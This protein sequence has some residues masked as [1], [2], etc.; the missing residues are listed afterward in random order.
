MSEEKYDFNSAQDLPHNIKPKLSSITF[1]DLMSFKEELLKELREYKSKTTKNINYEFEKYTQLIEKT[2]NKMDF[3]EKEKSTFLLKSEFTQEKNNILLEISVQQ[4]EIKKQI[5][6]NEVQIKNNSKEIQ[7]SIYRYDKAIIENLNVPG[8]VGSACRF[9]NLKEYILSN[10]DEIS[11]AVIANKKTSIEFKSFKKKMEISINQINEQ[12][13][14]LEY[15]ISNLVKSKFNELKEKFDSLYEA[16]NGK[17]TDES[18]KLNT[19]IDEKNIAIENI[20]A[21]VSEN[22][23]KLLENDALLKEELIKEIEIIKKSF[24]KIKKNIVNLTNLLMGKNNGLNKQMVINNFNNMMKGLYKEFNIDEMN[25]NFDNNNN[26]EIINNDSKYL[27]SKNMINKS[28]EKKRKSF[29]NNIKNNISFASQKKVGIGIIKTSINSSI[30]DYIAGKI[31]ADDA[32]FNAENIKSKYRHSKKTNNKDI[33]GNSKGIKN[34]DNI[35]NSN[36]KLSSRLSVNLNT[37]SNLFKEIKDI[38]SSFSENAKNFDNQN[39]KKRSSMILEKKTKSLNKII[40]NSFEHNSKDKIK[41]NDIINEE[42]SNKYTSSEESKLKIKGKKEIKNKRYTKDNIDINNKSLKLSLNEK[43]SKNHNSDSLTSQISSSSQKTDNSLDSSKL[44]YNAIKT[45][46]ENEKQNLN[47]TQNN[48]ENKNESIKSINNYCEKAV[49]NLIKEKFKFNHELSININNNFSEN[50]KF[51]NNVLNKI[52]QNS[53]INLK[54]NFNINS[55]KDKNKYNI[56]NNVKKKNE[57]IQIS[58]N[59]IN[60]KNPIMQHIISN[61]QEKNNSNNASD[62]KYLNYM[63]K[64]IEFQNKDLLIKT[65]RNK[66]LNINSN[67]E[68]DIGFSSFDWQNNKN[69]IQKMKLNIKDEENKVIKENKQSK[70]SKLKLISKSANKND[71][72]TYIESDT[73][74]KIRLIKDEDIVDKPL[75]FERNIFKIDKNKGSLEC[76]IIELEYFTKKKFDELVKEIRVFIPIHFNSH[77]KDYSLFK[78]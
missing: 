74:K 13:K 61:N 1:Q 59:Q 22:K 14:G 62:S 75:L 3:I 24:H 63:S 20:N 51:E 71:K 55:L 50:E 78:K 46:I 44:V 17:I 49:N 16:L 34:N 45:N 43:E 15:R 40:N 12:I 52:K 23:K 54:K 69:N 57:L 58:P 73:F 9:P 64:T 31:S 21:I 48:L 41:I 68:K 6:L 66:T 26:N 29:F 53:K 65:K 18:I 8:L 28:N 77:L 4:A 7:D 35:F 37:T 19:E 32:K 39:I 25:F 30:K 36:N 47:E 70:E 27:S 38:S 67:A 33:V 5:A 10:K 42:D 11:N 60:R 72:N 76:K 56:L 2:N